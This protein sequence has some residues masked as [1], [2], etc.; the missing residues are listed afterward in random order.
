MVDTVSLRE[1][2]ESR[3]DANRN[4]TDTRIRELE[5]AAARQVV[6]TEGRLEKL[7]EVKEQLGV[8]YNQ[9]NGQ[10]LLYLPRAEYTARHDQLGVNIRRVEDAQMK[11]TPL[12]IAESLK[13]ELRVL[14]EWKA[15]MSG[16]I[17]AIAAG[18]AVL[19]VLLSLMRTHWLG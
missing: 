10:L 18:M 11:Y 7:N 6:V 8:Q 17:W 16:R 14:S 4:H 13:L 15:N 9:F 3:I 12:E 2:V 19:Q 1:Y 5:A